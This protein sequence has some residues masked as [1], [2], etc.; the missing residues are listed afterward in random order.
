VA[1]DRPEPGEEIEVGL[2][3]LPDVVLFPGMS[4]P[5]HVFEPRYRRL[6]SDTLHNDGWLA[7][8]RLQPGYETN[9]HDCPAVHPVMGV[10][11]IVNHT[12]L[13]DGRYDIEVAGVLRLRLSR[14][15]QDEPYRMA[16]G[17]V[18]ADRAVG[19][20]ATTLHTELTK[21]VLRMR[22]FWS[23]AG[24]ELER[25]TLEASG[26]GACTDVLAQLLQT[27]D[28]RQLLLEELDP[29][30]RAMI[31][32]GRLHELWEHVERLG[33]GTGRTTSRSN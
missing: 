33:P 2:F 27:A 16:R 32:C 10:G 17:Q 20:A 7:V 21:L 12:R 28:D 18:L 14:E 9:Y 31:L 26:L 11:R 13:A 15:T 19:P 6:V 3:P 25:T 24:R 4:L 30:Q 8:P 23:E 5:L 22:P 29:S 1:N